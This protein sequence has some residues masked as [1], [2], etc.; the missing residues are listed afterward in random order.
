MLYFLVMDEFAPSVVVR[1][2]RKSAVLSPS[3]LPCLAAIPTVNLT[4]G[5]LHACL[6][7]YARSYSQYPGEGR[8]VLYDNTL[9]K[10][11][12]E[13]ARRRAAPRMVYFSPSSDIFQ[14]APEVLE[15]A[16]AVLG[17]LLSRRVGVAFSTK[18]HIPDR[19]LRLFA[20][21]AGHVHAQIGVITVDENVARTFEPNAARP[22]RRLAQIE[23]LVRA[24]VPTEARIDPILPAI[25]DTPKDIDAL[26]SA[27]ARA[28]IKRAIVSALF[29]RPAIIQ[30]LRR[31][32]L[33]KQML[34]RLYG[35]FDKVERGPG[36][37][38]SL[39]VEV[40]RDM[41]AR[42]RD[43]AAAYGIEVKICACKNPDLARGSC[44]ISGAWPGAPLS[45]QMPLLPPET[46][47]TGGT[48]H[49]A[50]TTLNPK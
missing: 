41:F 1:A 48:A 42:M 39:P 3:D 24:G 18:G 37:R 44:N 19:V 25:T 11:Q 22:S 8:T 47:A 32:L 40:R 23:T 29:L 28:G 34:A 13:L 50:L 14:P 31:N 17:F 4:A 45:L 12:D 5:C 26:F 9:E 30:S 49:E 6:Y 27:L 43:A 16:E 2:R 15:M 36:S 38:L 46:V 35:A 20:D 21:H 10:L 33:D 7:C